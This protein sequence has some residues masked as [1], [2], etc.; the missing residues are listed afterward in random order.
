VRS[1]S[2]NS[3][4]STAARTSARSRRAGARQLRISVA[5]ALRRL[6]PTVRKTQQGQDLLL[7]VLPKPR[8]A[9]PQRLVTA[10]AAPVLCVVW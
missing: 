3:S 6:W 8:L 7:S 9:P 4:C 1:T 5:S 2:A 10:A